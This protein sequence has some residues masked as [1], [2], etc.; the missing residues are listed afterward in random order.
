MF[1]ASKILL[2][3][4]GSPVWFCRW[5]SVL[6]RPSLPRGSVLTVFANRILY[7]RNLTAQ[8][9]PLHLLRRAAHIFIRRGGPRAKEVDN[10]I[11]AGE[12][13]R[14]NCVRST[15]NWPGAPGAAWVRFVKQ[16]IPW[17]APLL[18]G[19]S[20]RHC[21]NAD[22]ARWVRFVKTDSAAHPRA[23]LSVAPNAARVRFVKRRIRRFAVGRGAGHRSIT[24]IEPRGSVL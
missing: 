9:C 7:G 16:Q 5:F 15:R 21:D 2:G 20:R 12:Q 23:S 4:P 10:R 1:F 24:R 19:Q 3:A 6:P 18:H 11:T 14:P 22:T 8:V 17:F 13:S